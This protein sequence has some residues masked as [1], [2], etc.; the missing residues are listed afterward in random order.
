M[1]RL[2]DKSM[3][4][5]PDYNLAYD[6]LYNYLNYA[7][8]GDYARCTEKAYVTSNE[9]LNGYFPYLD[10]K[11]KKVATV[12]SS[13]DQVLNA[14]LYGSRDITLIDANIFAKP[15]T[16]YKMAL[17]RTFNRKQFLD[18]LYSSECFHWKVY[19]KISHMLSSE[20][21]MFFDAIMLDQNPTITKRDNYRMLYNCRDVQSYM[22]QGIRTFDQNLHSAFYLKDEY[23]N[24]LQEI[25]N[26]EDY[27]INYISAEFKDFPKKLKGK[28]D[29]IILSNIYDYVDKETHSIVCRLLYFNNLNKGGKI[30][31]A[32]DYDDNITYKNW[33]IACPQDVSFKTIKHGRFTDRVYYVERPEMEL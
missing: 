10:V 12:G 11:G 2:R 9:F 24:K 13:G 22:L 14:L 6:K 27:Q 30:Q 8:D 7:K 23:Y 19:S 16:E 25:L 3:I 18:M 17:M 28:F 26:K 1:F 15:F 31:L 4:G 5:N 33:G 32:Y 29:A 20:S 21:K